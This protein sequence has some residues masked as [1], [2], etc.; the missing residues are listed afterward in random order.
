MTVIRVHRL[1]QRKKIC[2]SFQPSCNESDPQSLDT[3]RQTP[4]SDRQNRKMWK[5]VSTFVQGE[6]TSWLCFLPLFEYFDI[7][8]LPLVSTS[9]G[10]QSFLSSGSCFAPKA[11]I[12]SWTCVK[13]FTSPLNQTHQVENCHAQRYPALLATAHADEEG[14]EAV[15]L[16]IFPVSGNFL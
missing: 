3:E 14:V 7:R 4:V 15:R 8:N 10:V 5:Y 12:S 13:L 16:A 2:R 11:C 9:F 6:S 1:C